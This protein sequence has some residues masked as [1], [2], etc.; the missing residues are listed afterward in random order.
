MSKILLSSILLF[1]VSCHKKDPTPSG[2]N[3][4]SCQIEG[5]NFTP[6]LGPAS[7]PFTGPPIKA[8]EASYYPKGRLLVIYAKDVY[9]QLSMGIRLSPGQ[10]TGSYTLGYTRFIYP[11]VS[12]PTTYGTYKSIPPVIQ[13]VTDPNNIPPAVNYSTDAIN[14]GT[15]TITR[16]DT[17][18]RE[19]V[20]TFNYT[21][22]SSA[23]GTLAHVSNGSF[24]ILF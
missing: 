13:G 3:T 19:A 9:N 5:K 1:L 21:A 4:F 14:T 7:Q 11:F 8:L 22:Y 18:A 17:I 10:G 20:G 2:P 24:D 12:A 15:V 16:L 23:A 6:Y